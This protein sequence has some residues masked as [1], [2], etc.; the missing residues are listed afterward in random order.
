MRYNDGLRA[1]RWAS[2]LGRGKRFF[3]SAPQGPD[4]LWGLPGLLYEV[5]WVGA[6]EAVPPGVKWPGCDANQS[7]P[8]SAEVKNGGDI[9]PLP[10]L[11]GK[12]R[13]GRKA[14][15]LTAICE[16]IV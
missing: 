15:Y 4:R 14:E 11:R 5:Q 6:G 12:G 3:F 9:P 16:P 7:P 8:S 2:I 1:G 13:P 10:I